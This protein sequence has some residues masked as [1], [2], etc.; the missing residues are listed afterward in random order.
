VFTAAILLAHV[1][2]RAH[3]LNEAGTLSR[4]KKTLRR[5]LITQRLPV[6]RVYR[7]AR[8]RALV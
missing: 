7:Q 8:G 2:T 5:E 1:V 6:T 3:G 4:V